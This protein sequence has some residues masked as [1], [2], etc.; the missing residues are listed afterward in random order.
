MART[1][2]TLA[3]PWPSYP[4][5]AA[6][7]V[8]TAACGAE[9]E[10][11]DEVD[12]LRV[13]G[14]QKSAP[15]AAPGEDVELS[16][17]WHD[18]TRDGS[19]VRRDVPVHRVWLGGCNNPL[20]DYYYSCLPDVLATLAGVRAAQEGISEAEFVQ[21]MGS[22]GSVTSMDRLSRALEDIPWFEGELP[23][24][25]LEVPLPYGQFGV[26]DRFTLPIPE[27]II[28]RDPA[29]REPYGLSIP[30]FAVCAGTIAVSAGA[31]DQVVPLVCKED[32]TDGEE[33]LLGS[34]D[35]VIGYANVYGYTELRNAN[36]KIDGF[37]VAGFQTAL[38]GETS[39]F[40]CVDDDCLVPDTPLADGADCTRNAE[41]SSG[42]CADLVCAAAPAPECGVNVPCIDACK[43][44]GD[45]EKCDEIAI[46]PLLDPSIA[47]AD[48]LSSIGGNDYEEQMWVNYHVDRGSV[49][50]VVRLVNDSVKGWNDEYDTDLFAPEFSAVDALGDEGERLA[51]LYLWAVV[52]DNRGGASWVRQ[53]VY[54]REPAD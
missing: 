9:L 29:G 11:P 38:T 3:W 41:C 10:S 32:R 7:L 19:G 30:F 36:P 27:D 44:D 52:R 4:L 53:T 39:A 40:V 31:F 37:E 43:D 20:G 25:P 6:L 49:A 8:G 21:A 42:Y 48:P 35:F 24:E 33:R 22:L 15:Y 13:L 2:H 12:S 1:T 5:A 16:L 54:V 18:G 14:V 47:E 23:K 51:P 45:A 34:E 17:L 26:G 50:S 46:R 28:Q